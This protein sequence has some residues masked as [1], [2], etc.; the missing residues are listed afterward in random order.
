MTSSGAARA[1]A[2]LIGDGTLPV[3]LLNAGLREEDLSPERADLGRR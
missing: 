3:E 2:G 1:A